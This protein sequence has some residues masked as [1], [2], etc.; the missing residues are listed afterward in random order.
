M[1]ETYQFTDECDDLIVTASK[2][3]DKT[4]VENAKKDEESAMISGA[5]HYP[6]L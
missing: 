1:E 5:I 6:I 4:A 2:K 3:N